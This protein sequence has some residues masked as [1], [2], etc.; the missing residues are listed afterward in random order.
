MCAAVTAKISALW[1]DSVS[2]T[3]LRCHSDILVRVVLG[4]CVWEALDGG[5]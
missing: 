2:K 4:T 1:C 3:F 5:R